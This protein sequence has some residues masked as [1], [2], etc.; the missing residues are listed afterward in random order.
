ME[1][2]NEPKC[3]ESCLAEAKNN[4]AGAEAK[5]RFSRTECLDSAALKPWDL[6]SPNQAL[7]QLFIDTMKQRPNERD[8]SV[9]TNIMGCCIFVALNIQWSIQAFPGLFQLNFKQKQNK[10]NMNLFLG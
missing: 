3:E 7:T 6:K 5:N 9:E 8:M 4:A 10:K 2:E 1:T